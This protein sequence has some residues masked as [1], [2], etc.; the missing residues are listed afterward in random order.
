MKASLRKLSL[1][2]SALAAL[3]PA[4]AIAQPAAQQTAQPAA[5]SK[6]LTPFGEYFLA[7][8]GVTDYTSSA[9]KDRT[10]TG[11]VWDLRLG[12]G[13]RYF[14]GGEIGYVGSYRDANQIGSDLT[15]NGV[16][17]VVRVQY[18]YTLTGG[19][20]LEP[21][22][23]GGVGWQHFELSDRTALAL[24]KSDDVFTMPFGGGV[25]VAYDRFILDT[26]FTYRQT[27]NESLIR[28]NDGSKA[29]LSSW[30]VTMSLGYEF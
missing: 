14:V 8:G 11:G 24:H 9:V 25:T 13:S 26:R 18:P 20:M 16:E 5:Q 1:L 27:F 10:D 2:A 17:G 29:D 22:A 7:G 21:F 23:F 15:T 6:L 28:D 3:S 30:A 19:L 4:L 12:F